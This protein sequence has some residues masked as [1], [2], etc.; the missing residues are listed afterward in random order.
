MFSLG[1]VTYKALRGGGR[2]EDSTG[3]RDRGTPRAGL[4]PVLCAFSGITD[5]ILA[6]QGR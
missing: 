4:I 6:K 2:L 5:R 1:D 3:V